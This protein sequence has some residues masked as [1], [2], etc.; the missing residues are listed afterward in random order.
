MWSVDGIQQVIGSRGI[1]STCLSFMDAGNYQSNLDGKPLD[2][3]ESLRNVSQQPQGLCFIQ[4]YADTPHQRLKGRF[5]PVSGSI[6]T[7]MCLHHKTAQALYRDTVTYLTQ[8]DSTIR[9]YSKSS[10]RLELV[11]HSGN[12][13][14]HV[15]AK[16]YLNYDGLYSLLDAYPML[17]HVPNEM[18]RT[19]ARIETFMTNELQELYSRYKGT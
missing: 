19:V 15:R 10:C 13:P 18:I 8:M 17:V 3:K 7:G 5:H 4:M 9:C 16:D 14:E 6:I 1:L 12:P 11:V 2:F